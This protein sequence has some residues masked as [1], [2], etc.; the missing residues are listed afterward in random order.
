M[1]LPCRLLVGAPEA[2]GRQPG[3][4]K[5]GAVYKCSVQRQGDCQIIDFD[6]N[7]NKQGDNDND[8]YYYSQQP[9]YLINKIVSPGT[10]FARTGQAYDNKSGQWLGS[11]LAS[12]GEDGT[13]MVGDCDLCY[14]SI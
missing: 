9:I 14:L 10:T 11:L 13:V 8:Y 5:G 7:G 4:H 12:S 2:D 1:S 3:V 6:K